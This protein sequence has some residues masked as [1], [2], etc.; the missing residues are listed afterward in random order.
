MIR[1]FKF[2]S[3]VVITTERFTNIG[4]HL[5]SATKPHTVGPNTW[6]SIVSFLVFSILR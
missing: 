5:T 1:K 4:L 3:E 2:H 6:G